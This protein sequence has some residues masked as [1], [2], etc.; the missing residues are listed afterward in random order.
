MQ[1]LSKMREL[2]DTWWH[3]I[4]EHG[5]PA[6][7]GPCPVQY[8]SHEP[9]VPMVKALSSMAHDLWLVLGLGINH[10]LIA[11]NFCCFW[12]YLAALWFLWGSRKHSGPLGIILDS[13]N[14]IGQLK[15]T[16]PWGSWV[17]LPNL[18]TKTSWSK[19]NCNLSQPSW[20]RNIFLVWWNELCWFLPVHSVRNTVGRGGIL[21]SPYIAH[22]N[23]LI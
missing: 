11:S 10:K 3:Q 4:H 14:C 22:C 1:L 9:L 21:W 16:H 20:T 19:G 13:L 2:R 5:P 12:N 7:V 23:F 15:F 18:A 6:M 8:K 17:A